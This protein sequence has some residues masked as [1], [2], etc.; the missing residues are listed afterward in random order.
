MAK[1]NKIRKKREREEE[2]KFVIKTNYI[3]SM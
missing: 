1:E 2:K 3:A